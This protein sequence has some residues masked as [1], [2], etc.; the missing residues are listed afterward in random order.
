M[1]VSFKAD[2]SFGVPQ[3]LFLGPL[4]LALH[5]TPLSSIISGHAI[6]HHLYAGDSQLYVSL[7]QVTLL[8][9]WMVFNRDWLLSSLGYWWINLNWIQTKRNS[10][11]LGA[12]DIGKNISL[13]FV[14]RFLVSQ[15]TQQKPARNHGVLFDRKFTFHSHISA[16]CTSRFYIIRDLWRICC[17]RN[18]KSANG[19]A[20]VFSCLH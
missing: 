9:H 8:Q 6:P 20:L 3:G 2:L 12:N 19:N 11:L 15:L 7:H 17:Y 18:L 16:V 4:L 10:S 1:Q 14:L 13:C 5:S